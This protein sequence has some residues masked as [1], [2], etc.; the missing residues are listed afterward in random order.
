MMVMDGGEVKLSMLQTN[1][2]RTKPARMYGSDDEQKL[3]K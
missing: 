2:Q 1:M 3:D